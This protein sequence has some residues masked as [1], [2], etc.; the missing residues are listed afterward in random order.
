M[1]EEEKMQN[2]PSQV[3]PITCPQCGS[4]ELAFVTHHQKELL[5]RIACLV[6]TIISLFIFIANILPNAFVPSSSLA[7]KDTVPFFIFAILAIVF[8]IGALIRESETHV[9]AV[10]KNCGHIWLLN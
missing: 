2:L 4:T 7:P 10:C 8:W 5:L 9:Q 6:C 3:K 1:N